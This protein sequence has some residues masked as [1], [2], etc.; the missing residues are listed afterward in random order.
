MSKIAIVYFSS[1]GNTEQMANILEDALKGKA[2][3]SVIAPENFTAAQVADYDAIAF[4]CSA[5]GQE[6]LEET[7]YEPMFASVEGSLSGK[8]I[9]LFGSYAWA[10]GEWMRTWKDRVEGDGANLVCEPVIAFEAP[11]DAAKA[12]LE[13]MA[14]ALLA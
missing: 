5:Q 1:T 2:E 8:K 11:D 14:E 12:D 10:D 7:V 6:E 3:V 9:A 4:G 13:K